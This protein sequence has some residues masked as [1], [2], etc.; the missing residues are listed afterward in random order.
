MKVWI[1]AALGLLL[2]V[3]ALS[4]R[5]ADEKA[6]LAAE[7]A[8]REAVDTFKQAQ[9]NVRSILDGPYFARGQTQV[10]STCGT[11]D[12]LDA[13]LA[14]LMES[15]AGTIMKEA[16]M[17]IAAQAA[18]DKATQQQQRLDSLR[19]DLLDASRAMLRQVASDLRNCRGEEQ[20]TCQAEHLAGI[21]KRLATALNQDAKVGDLER[22][23]IDVIASAAKAQAR[24][25]EVKASTA[26][27]YAL[28]DEAAAT[29]LNSKAADN[30]GKLGTELRAAADQG[31]RSAETTREAVVA[32]QRASNHL[33]RSAIALLECAE[34]DEACLKEL[35][36][37]QA[38][39]SA[40]DFRL[41]SSLTKAGQ[42]YQ[43]TKQANWAAAAGKH[44]RLAD[45][46]KSVAF[47]RL[48]DT[49]PDARSLVGEASAAQINT[50]R[51]G[52]DATIKI[53]LGKSGLGGVERHAITLN[54]PLGDR[55]LVKSPVS[56]GYSTYWLRRLEKSM[57]E[58]EVDLLWVTGFSPKVDF[59]Q[60]SYRDPAR[61][62]E[63]IDSRA[64]A[65]TISAYFGWYW[66]RTESPDLHL[67]TVD[68]KRYY[69]HA[70]SAIRCAAPVTGPVSTCFDSEFAAPEKKYGRVFKYQWRLKTRSIAL[71]PTLSYDQRSKEKRLE[72][73]IYLWR[74]E[75][76]DQPFNAGI[77][78]DIGS[79]S[80]DRVG[81]FVGTSFDP[82]GLPER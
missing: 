64:R 60:H 81:L 59:L 35:A 63:P 9:A 19:K 48:L 45:R 40:A 20:P 70:E 34:R 74:P 41:A 75:G 2:A 37:T 57:D 33:V 13:D 30:K 28:G 69:E 65:W 50:S 39:A 56:L 11:L 68:V 71:S 21:V 58:N 3:P 38:D 17:V 73:P 8:R 54:A 80:A 47:A 22:A 72:L 62:D 6:E 14:G 12:Q 25:A 1:H 79:K 36:R 24:V 66:M 76:K 53:S 82:F 26:N 51:E 27:A 61:I 43:L 23:R 15:D 42:A 67:F 7:K 10:T 44:A 78:F 5:A 32:A 18:C 49:Y 46:Q 77:K 31:T 4:A 16:S 52:T 29:V 55:D